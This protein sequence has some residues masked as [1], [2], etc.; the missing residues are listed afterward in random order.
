MHVYIHEINRSHRYDKKE[1]I[2]NIDTNQ[3]NINI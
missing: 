3:V 2:I 1:L